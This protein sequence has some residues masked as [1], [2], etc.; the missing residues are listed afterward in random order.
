M[1]F[2]LKKLLA[3]FLLPPGLFITLLFLSG[4]ILWR[5]KSRP[6]ALFNLVLGLFVW[7]FCLNPIADALVRGLEKDLPQPRLA[8]TDVVIV[9]SGY[10]DRTAPA[11][12][13]QRRLGVPIIFSGYVALRH[14]F[15]DRDNF[16]LLLERL[17]VPRSKVILETFSRDTMENLRLAREICRDRGFRRPVI[18]SS[19]F[20]GRRVLL[21]M[22]KAGLQAE[23]YP[24]DF[25]VVGR[26]VVYTWRDALPEARALLG[27]SQ[28]AS[29]YLGLLFYRI[30]Y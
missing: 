1:I 13:L 18:V 11:I 29:E 25:S 20:H 8:A 27:C 26:T 3:A 4:V 22:K 17:G 16:Y 19:A 2:V 14:S 9:L 30:F 23:L 21:S 7:V 5:R 6:A 28:A 24:V 15:Q 10:G 12:Q